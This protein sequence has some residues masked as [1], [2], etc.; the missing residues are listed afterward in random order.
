MI[1]VCLFVCA[2]LIE[3]LDRVIDLKFSMRVKDVVVRNKC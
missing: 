1:F 2:E 3:E